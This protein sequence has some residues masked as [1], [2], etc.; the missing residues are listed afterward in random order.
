VLLGLVVGEHLE[1]NADDGDDAGEGGRGENLHPAGGRAAAYVGKA[2]YPARDA[3]AQ[4]CAHDYAYGLTHLHH[5]G[6]NEADYHDGGGRG[7]LDDGCDAGAQQHA[8]QRGA[9]ELIEH[10][11]KFVAGDFLQAVPHEVHAEQEQSHAAKQ[12]Y[13]IRNAQ[14][15]S[16]PFIDTRCQI[17][18]H[19]NKPKPDY[20]P[21][22]FQKI[23]RFA[24]V[25]VPA[26]VLIPM[27]GAN[28]IQTES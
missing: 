13:Y 12:R 5:A 16:T 26:A 17:I 3:G 25:A 23:L 1:Y 7:G 9:G 19:N 27:T 21:Y 24:P 11:L 2:K 6:V 10:K 20:I 15:V 28:E 22:K 14:I 18:H 4:N 8:L